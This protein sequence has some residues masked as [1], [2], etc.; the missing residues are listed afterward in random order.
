M[1]SMSELESRGTDLESFL[2]FPKDFLWGVSTA[3]HQVEG[4][5]CNQWT[6]WEQAGRIKSGDACGRACDWWENPERDFDIAR[7][8]GLKALR[9]SLEWSRIEPEENRFDQK[10]LQRYRQMLEGL[11][12]RGIEPIVCLHHFTHP[13]WFE[14]TGAF[15]RPEAPQ[16]FDRFARAV[17]NGVG[18]LC[19]FWVTFNEPNV[20]AACG[21]VLG[22]FP[23]GRKGELFNALRVNS[24][25][26]QAHV[27][28]YGAIHQLVP[29]AQVGW[30]Q[31]Y[32][33][34]EP[35]GGIV[36]RWV[37]TRLD[38]LF[39]HVF[40]E[41]IEDGR[42]SFPFNLWNGHVRDAKGCC[43]FVGLNV[44]S[45]FHVA[46]DIRQPST[47][48]TRLYVPEHVPQGDPGVENPYGEAYPQAI[49][50]A[51]KRAARLGK[52]IYIMENGV[53]DAADRIRPWLI[54]NALRELH[55][56]IECGHDIRGYLHWTLTDN[57]EWN[58]G[59]RLR[60]GLVELDPATQ[61]RTLRSS[62]RLFSEIIRDNGLAVATRNEEPLLSK[63]IP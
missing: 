30:A 27:L 45:R 7:D 48:F 5:N 53:P 55:R 63:A 2:R 9:L 14:K 50:R 8:I 10:A 60:F 38:R 37:A 44:Y 3:A 6:D 22:E 56:L 21:Y 18:D 49:T 51:V 28:A 26:A 23:P 4:N 15:L 24:M 20:Y 54:V 19:R 42:L 62:A 13:R 17:A 31:H 12:E 34:F 35:A 32:V 39:N 43:D 58:E 1:Q 25:Q 47:L 40:F 41:L 61:Q 11:R 29:E 57:F 59:W 46:L 36:D 52:P 33:V 16:L